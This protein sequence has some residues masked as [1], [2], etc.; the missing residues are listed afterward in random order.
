MIHMSD[1][2]QTYGTQKKVPNYIPIPNI[3]S[4]DILAF[5]VT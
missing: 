1:M 4:K 5:I 3:F 2:T